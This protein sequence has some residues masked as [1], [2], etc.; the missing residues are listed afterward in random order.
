MRV[1]HLFMPFLTE[2]IWQKLPHNGASITVAQWPEV[3]EEF[4]DL[5]ETK[6]MKRLVSIINSVR[7]IRAEL[8]T[9]R[10]KEITLLIQAKNDEIVEE[11]KNERAYLERFCNP[12][13][14][15]IATELDVPEKAMS[16]VVTGAEIFLPLEGL[17]DF[18]KEI[19]RLEK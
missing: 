13:E 10:S 1:L 8:D 14:L 19:E 12:S 5:Q 16:A 2:E 7:N 3:K 11:L 6:E 17:I 4:H 9:S 18:D 15:V